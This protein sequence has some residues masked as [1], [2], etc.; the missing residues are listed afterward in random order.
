[1]G[2]DNKKSKE[3]GVIVNYTILSLFILSI[4]ILLGS[5]ESN[6][7]SKLIFASVVIVLS[8]A[9]FIESLK[10]RIEKSKERFLSDLEKL[11]LIAKGILNI[12]VIFSSYVVIVSDR[13]KIKKYYNLCRNTFVILIL[14]LVARSILNSIKSIREARKENA[15]VIKYV[16][17]VVGTV[18]TIL[19]SFSLTFISSILPLNNDKSKEIFYGNNIKKPY[20]LK[21]VKN[22]RKSSIS[23]MSDWVD[24]Y[25]E[26]GSIKDKKIIDDFY[27]EVRNFKL[28]NMKYLEDI[29]YEIRRDNR[30]PYYE[31]G[32]KYKPS[33]KVIEDRIEFY[34]EGEVVIITTNLNGDNS[35]SLRNDYV[36]KYYLPLSD[37]MIQRIKEA[38]EKLDESP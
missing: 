25:K 5:K 34:K 35:N 36:K 15:K 37:K 6:V 1:M 29:N 19:A 9:I 14:V 13:F 4:I 10:E 30:Y 7:P 8:V 38:I 28:E 24:S 21:V 31:I 20:E 12:L 22:I 23:N 17:I 16:G 26:I 11:I 3:K 18:I 2:E 27:K 32:L 33:N